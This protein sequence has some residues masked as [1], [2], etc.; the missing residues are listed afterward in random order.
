MRAMND[1][2]QALIDKK[3]NERERETKVLDIR[4][5]PYIS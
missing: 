5:A 2:I 4:P 3:V 1:G